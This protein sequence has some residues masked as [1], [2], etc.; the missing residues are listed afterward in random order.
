MGI[1]RKIVDWIKSF[2]TSP[3][4]ADPIKHVIVLM[5]ENHS[6][7][8]MLG[9][10]QAV[11]PGEIDGIDAV[12]PGSNKDSTGQ[13]YLQRMSSDPVV[14]PD[15]RHELDHILNQLK[16]G[17]SGFVS[18]YEKEYPATTPQQRQR[19]MDYFGRDDLPALHVIVEYP[20][21]T[22]AKKSSFR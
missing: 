8:Q 1:F 7:D 20:R 3:A 2:T 15:P 9:C 19:I 5:F 22:H 10:F 16:D 17:N 14:S 21:N 18:E 11:F 4:N 13:V 6:F 12:S